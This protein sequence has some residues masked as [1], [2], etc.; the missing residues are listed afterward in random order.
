[1][2]SMYENQVWT[3]VNTLKWIKPIGFK[4]IFKKKTNMEGNV[5]TYKARFVPKAYH[6]KQGVDY[7]KTFS[8]VFMLKS[9][10][11]ILSIVAHYDY[12]IWKMDVK[13]TFL[14]RNLSKDVYMTQLES[15]TSKDGSQVYMQALKIHL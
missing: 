7:D 5:V 3:L 9:I 8:T 14:N 1:M 10:R 13:T 4:W 2:D 12:E 15:F 6:Q 11:I